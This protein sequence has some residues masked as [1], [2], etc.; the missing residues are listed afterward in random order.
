M[1]IWNCI[2]CDHLISPMLADSQRF[3]SPQA[4]NWITQALF[5]LSSVHH[6]WV[7]TSPGMHWNSTYSY[8]KEQI[9]CVAIEIMQSLCLTMNFCTTTNNN[10]APFFSLCLLF[11]SLFFPEGVYIHKPKGCSVIRR[12]RL[13][14]GSPEETEGVK[15]V[16]CRRGVLQFCTHQH[17]RHP[18][19]PAQPLPSTLHLQ[20][21][22]WQRPKS[23]ITC[24]RAAILINPWDPH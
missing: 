19:C 18:A 17:S 20:K 1:Y 12:A 15:G 5:T 11:K 2:T 13:C 3:T 10:Q 14:T 16:P 21:L 24:S 7:T 23:P 4:N 22:Q 9:K 6:T 8:Q